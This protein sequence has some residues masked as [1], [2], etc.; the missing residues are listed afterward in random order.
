MPPPPLVPP[1]EPPRP[2]VRL[3]P[4]V[5]LRVERA[6]A[7]RAVAAAFVP[8][9]RAAPLFFA[10]DVRDLAAPLLAPAERVAADFLAVDFL[11]PVVRADEREALETP[12]A[13]LRDL[14]L[15]AVPPSS[16]DHLPD[17][18]RWAASATASAIS[19]PSRVALETAALAACEAV[20]AASIPASRILRR[21][22]GLAA[23]AAA[24]AV[25]PAASIS[26]LIAAFASLSIVLSFERECDPPAED[27]ALVDFDA[28]LL[29]DDFD[30]DEDFRLLDFAI[31][32][33]PVV[34]A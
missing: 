34:A 10:V 16:S 7:F 9:L 20:S 29:E 21:A 26:R 15:L 24:A 31:A 18:T 32:N 5:V 23:I 8:V 6:G 19:E 4:P 30:P 13:V 27:F 2:P 12:P 1:V 25:R 17:S 14:P 11:V 22:V 3:A 33:L 28:L